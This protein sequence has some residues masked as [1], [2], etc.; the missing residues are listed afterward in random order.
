[1]VENQLKT[2]N[3]TILN[4]YVPLSLLFFFFSKLLLGSTKGGLTL[5]KK[6]ILKSNIT[7]LLSIFYTSGIVVLCQFSSSDK[8]VK[9]KLHTAMKLTVSMNCSHTKKL[10]FELLFKLEFLLK[11]FRQ[12]G[13]C[14]L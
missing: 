4:E 12:E 10:L 11:S 7:S 9:S 13:H 1:M 6:R 2:F 14:G 8:C 3:S 5:V